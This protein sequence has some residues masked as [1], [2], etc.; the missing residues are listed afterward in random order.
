MKLRIVMVVLLFQVSQVRSQGLD[1]NLL[2]KL[3][4]QS[5]KGADKA[6]NIIS[7][8]AI[9]I[10]VAT[11][12]AMYT[13]GLIADDQVL[14]ENA[15]KT[16]IS[17]AAT[18]AITYA[19]K[20]SFDRKRPFF[21]YPDKIHSS[22]NSKGYS[23]PSGHTST[24]FSLATSLSLSYPKWYVIVPS[25]TFAAA[26]AYSRMYKGVHYPSDVLGGMVVGAGTSYL[27][28]KV[29]KLLQKKSDRKRPRRYYR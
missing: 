20:S 19:M 29:Q 9:P 17:L 14:K 4:P 12:F 2:D 18:T 25:Y 6:M 11:P 27:T 8:G 13:I 21:A 15:V 26:T 28:W 1:V 24:A 5:S 23:F 16:G 22:G 3:N 10:S 7:D